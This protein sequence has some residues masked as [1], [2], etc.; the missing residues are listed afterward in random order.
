MLKRPNFNVQT[1]SCYKQVLNAETTPE[2]LF[3]A[4]RKHFCQKDLGIVILGVS[5]NIF[6]CYY[7]YEIL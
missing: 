4:R 5:H 7:D 6:R 1:A 3:C 2:P